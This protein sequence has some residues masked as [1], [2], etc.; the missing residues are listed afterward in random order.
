MI[1]SAAGIL[2]LGLA[3]LVYY[4]DPPDLLQPSP[5]IT[6]GMVRAVLGT[7][8]LWWVSLAT[9]IF[10]VLQTVWLSFLVLYL[11]EV[12]H[13]S[14]VSAAGYL[15][16]A[17]LTG[18]LGRVAFGIL[19]D[20][21]FGGQRRIVLFLAGTG[22]MICSLGIAATGSGTPSWLLSLLALTFGFVGIGWNGVQYTLMAELAGPRVAGT[23]VGLGLA[24]S[25]LGVTLGPPLFGWAVERSEATERPG[26]A[27]R[28]AW[29][30]P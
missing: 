16:Q 14:L 22:S 7:A 25:S 30:S 4:R 15:A 27:W 6:F 12:I 1:A 2:I 20:R 24:V 23:A 29:G 11:H 26:L 17:Q 10:A 19:S 18:I 21:V 3:T 9:L 13:L 5:A 8:D 28:P